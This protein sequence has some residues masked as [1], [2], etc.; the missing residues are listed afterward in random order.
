MY[1]NNNTN[2]TFVAIPNTGNICIELAQWLLKQQDNIFV[3]LSN[4]RPIDHNRNILVNEFL[5][6]DCNWL[7]M[8]DSDVAPPVNLLEM[9]ENNVPVCS[10]Y[11]S[12]CVANEIIPVGMTKNDTGYYHD[13]K[14]SAP[15]LHRVDAVGTGCILIRRDVFDTLKKPYFKFIYD[16]DGILT[17]GEDFYF[18]EKVGREVYFDARY[19]CKHTVSVTI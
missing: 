17:K 10:A 2:K 16:A 6:S 5:K 15:E 3:F 9:C 11:V 18:S 7:L 14:H 4:S 8:I 12:T 19:K 1:N 13:F